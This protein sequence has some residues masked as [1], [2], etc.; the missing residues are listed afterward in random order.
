[1]FSSHSRFGYLGELDVVIITSTSVNAYVAEDG[2]TFYV[3]ED[4]TTLYVTE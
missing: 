1:M 4:G 3:A 2:I